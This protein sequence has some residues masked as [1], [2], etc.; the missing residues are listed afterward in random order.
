MPLCI[1]GRRERGARGG[2]SEKLWPFD[3]FCFD[4]PGSTV[5]TW[6]LKFLDI[7]GTSF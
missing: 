4:T 6:N 7:A 3:S 5:V 2:P 1:Q